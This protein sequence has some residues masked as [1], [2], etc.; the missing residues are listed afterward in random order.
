MIASLT[1]TIRTLSPSGITLQIGPVGLEVRVPTSLLPSLKVGEEVSLATHLNVSD[2]A[3]DLYAFA[4]EADRTFFRQLMTVT[5]VGPKSALQVLSLDPQDVRR[6]I[7]AKDLNAL[8]SIPGVGKKRAQR[9]ILELASALVDDDATPAKKGATRT[10][11]HPLAA[12]LEP[13]LEKLGYDASEIKA[14]LAELPPDI[15]A[16]ENAL[17]FLLSRAR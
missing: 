2:S 12:A 11:K 1:G 10:P 4:T 6:A 7:A 13:A 9:L 17:R 16:P 14:M 15:A 3:L 8:S 5:G